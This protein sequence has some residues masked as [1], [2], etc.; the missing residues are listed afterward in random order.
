MF[1]YRV[2]DVPKDKQML[3]DLLASMSDDSWHL[4]ALYE[5]HQPVVAI[6]GTVLH[7]VFCRSSLSSILMPPQTEPQQ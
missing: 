2:I 4:I 7:G 6:G 5:T 1:D 3:S